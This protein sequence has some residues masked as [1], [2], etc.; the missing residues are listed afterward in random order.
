[1]K[2]IAKSSGN[3][4]YKD[5]GIDVTVHV[6]ASNAICSIVSGW[7]LGRSR[8]RP[9]WLSSQSDIALIGLNNFT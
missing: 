8:C 5:R 3:L 1:M 6:L 7:M 2:H 4:L 9:R